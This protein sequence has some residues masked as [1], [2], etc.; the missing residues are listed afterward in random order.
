MI[1]ELRDVVTSA[2][3][4]P[5]NAFVSNTEYFCRLL[6]F[7]HVKSAKAKGSFAERALSVR[8]AAAGA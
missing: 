2:L 7:S 6:P 5:V 8:T 1:V 4:S 3:T